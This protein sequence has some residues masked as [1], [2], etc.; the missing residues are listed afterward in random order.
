MDRTDFWAEA[1]RRRNRA[2]LWIP[3]WLI[4]GTILVSVFDDALPTAQRSWAPTLALAVW[5]GIFMYLRERIVSMRCYRC[6]QRAF[7]QIWV[8][9]DVSR[10]KH[11]GAARD[12]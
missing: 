4:V 3:G 8:P 11:C 10:C 2:L 5:F 9:L 6:G 7:A 1:K 12:H